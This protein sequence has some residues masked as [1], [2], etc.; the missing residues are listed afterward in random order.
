MAVDKKNFIK[1]LF[2]SIGIFGFMGFVLIFIS[3]ASEK[4]IKI[5]SVSG[6]MIVGILSLTML[7]YIGSK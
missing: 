3:I 2:I 4:L 5:M 7:I 6:I 1:S